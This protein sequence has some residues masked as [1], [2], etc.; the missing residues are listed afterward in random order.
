MTQIIMEGH[1]V[2]LA[3]YKVD[4]AYFATREAAQAIAR[5]LREEKWNRW[6][7]LRSM[8]GSTA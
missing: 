1:T 8:S 4:Q 7:F 3:R 5:I 6:K 2:R